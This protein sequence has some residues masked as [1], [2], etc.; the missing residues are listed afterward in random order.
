MK[1]EKSPPFRMTTTLKA[2]KSGHFSWSQIDLYYSHFHSTIKQEV[3]EFLDN[4]ISSLQEQLNQL[5]A[6]TNRF[7]SVVQR[8]FSEISERGN[9]LINED[10]FDG[11][12]NMADN[13]S[14]DSASVSNL[15]SQQSK[16]TTSTKRSAKTAKARRKQ[17]RKKYNSKP[18]SR[19]EHLGLL[20]EIKKIY[21]NLENCLQKMPE[22]IF[23]G[24][25]YN[26]NRNTLEEAKN[27]CKNIIK[28]ANEQTYKIWPHFNTQDDGQSPGSS[29]P[30]PGPHGDGSQ[31]GDFSDTV[32]YNRFKF[33]RTCIET[34]IEVKQLE[35]NYQ[36]EF[37][38]RV[39][40]L[41][42]D[43]KHDLP[44]VTPSFITMSFTDFD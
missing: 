29:S 1:V 8:R 37:G 30:F 10:L 36:R 4:E 9:Q 28:V 22:I 31:F 23:T 3:Q 13:M 19:S 6:Y 21:V 24:R 14:I 33:I 15:S 44:L 5:L 39:G 18:G 27:S 25:V 41:Y 2:C 20:D 26:L 11:M 16:S 40:G 7:T 12:G 38:H 35:E 17:A 42:L 43:V 32:V 34:G